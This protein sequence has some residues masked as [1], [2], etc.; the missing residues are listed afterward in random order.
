ME[1]PNVL[2]KNEII[3]RLKALGVDV[4]E[5]KLE[6]PPQEVR[7][8]FAIPCFRIRNGR[9]EKPSEKAKRL[10]EVLRSIPFDFTAGIKAEG[11]YLN[12]KLNY[13]RFGAEVLNNILLMDKRYGAENIGKGKRVVVDMSS[14][15][16]AKRMGFGHFPP[17]IIGESIARIYA[18]EGYEIIRDNHIGDWGT[19]FGKLIQATKEWSSEEKIAKAKDPIGALQNLYVRFHKEAE[20][21]PELEEKAKEWFLRLEKGDPEARRIWQLCVDVSLKEFEEIYELLN[22]KFELVRGE[23]FYESML[24]EVVNK[25]REEIGEESE[26]ALVVNMEDM[27]LKS[28]IIL[29]SDGATVYMTRDIACAINRAEELKADEIIYVVGEPQK[30]Y[31]QQLF[32]VLKRLGYDIADNCV[33]VYFGTISLPEGKMSTRAG[34]VILLKDVLHEAI[35]R[36]EKAIRKKN[37]KLFKDAKKREEVAKQVGTGAIV[38]QQVSQ[39]RKRNIVFE[40]NKMLSFD[41]YSGPYVQY[42][43]A[44]ACSILRKAGISPTDLIPGRTITVEK[45]SERQLLKELAHFPDVI[46]EAAAL[47]EPAIIAN[48]IFGLT[49]TFSRFY[50]DCPVLNARDEKLKDSRMKLVAATTQVIRNG[51]YLLA[52]EAPEGM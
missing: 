27:G 48:Y 18:F 5:L 1:Y 50:R 22:I 23:S 42:A 46:R 12:F 38:W 26:G 29:K 30:F 8:D 40:W 41:G 7:A 19:Q 15:N 21:H 2:V 33:H 10:A 39:D 44:R 9:K 13:E 25:V 51:L 31:F 37:P 49:Q 52:I 3:G 36:A 28:A 32:E 45:D 16:I 4:S 11:P 14:P 6:A 43:H 34:R 20:K 24:P 17:T 35:V 47:Y